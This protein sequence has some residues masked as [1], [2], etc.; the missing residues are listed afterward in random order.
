MREEYISAIYK[1]YLGRLEEAKA[2]L[3]IYLDNPVAI[4]EHSGIGAEIHK[5]LEEIDKYHSL[6]GTLQL[7]FA[8]PPEGGSSAPPVPPQA[9]DDSS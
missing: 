3:N 1:Q 8:A 5:K 2:D 9:A 7:L 6:I 4:G